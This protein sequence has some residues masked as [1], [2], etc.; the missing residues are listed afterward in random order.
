MKYPYGREILITGASSGLGRAAAETFARTGYTVWGVSRRATDGCEPIGSGCIHTLKMDVCDEASVACALA[1]ITSRGGDP[2]IVLHCAGFGIG[3]AAEDT[4]IAD[5]QAQL[6]TNFFGVLRVNRAV[7]PRLRA[8]GNGLV[9]LVGS[10]AG[11]IPIPYQGHYSASKFA[12]EAYGEALRMEA[13]PCGVRVC[14]LEPGDTKTGFTAGRRLCIPEDSPYERSCRAS[15]RKMERDEQNGA[16]P[17]QFARVALR[18]SERRH[19]P[20]RRVIGLGYRALVLVKRLLPAR[21]AE[22]V[23]SRLYIPKG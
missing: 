4:P 15:V 21:T 16:P 13:R 10:V 23:L 14:L 3:G 5:A 18:M 2:G 22:W 19:P 12:L 20:V 1:E 7:M 11:L 17:E 6:D 8:R 9:L